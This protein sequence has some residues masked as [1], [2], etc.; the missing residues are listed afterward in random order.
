[1]AVTKRSVPR[2]IA[3]AVKEAFVERTTGEQF[4]KN[5]FE[6][7]RKITF[8]DI[9]PGAV[10]SAVQ[11]GL[12]NTSEEM[13]QAVQTTPRLFSQYGA[14]L[15]DPEEMWEALPWVTAGT[16]WEEVPEDATVRVIFEEFRGYLDE[17]YLQACLVGLAPLIQRAQTM[18][19]RVVKE[20]RWAQ[21]RRPLSEVDG[22][23]HVHEIEDAMWALQVL[24]ATCGGRTSAGRPAQGQT[25]MREE[26]A[27]AQAEQAPSLTGQ[28]RA[29]AERAPRLTGQRG[30]ASEEPEPEG[31]DTSG[32]RS[33]CAAEEGPEEGTDQEETAGPT[34]WDPG[35]GSRDGLHPQRDQPPRRKR[36]LGVGGEARRGELRVLVDSQ[37]GGNQGGDARVR[38]LPA[39]E[40]RKTRPARGTQS[41]G[42]GALDGALSRS[43]R[44][45]RRGIGLSR[46]GPQH[47]LLREIT[48]REITLR[49]MAEPRK[50]GD[51]LRSQAGVGVSSSVGG[52]TRRSG[53]GT[54]SWERSADL[55]REFESRLLRGPGTV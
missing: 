15:A 32:H 26:D 42:L 43:G 1:M 44:R 40:E 50:G 22:V 33:G 5:F 47:P 45:R 14:D 51:E 23:E 25:R 31:E 13:Q 30:K 8:G 16:K 20:K 49:G 24:E 52:G 9:A 29:Q 6:K 37:G 11:A 39:P 19:E 18:G 38:R 17:D 12:L 3:D 36:D 35:G 34:V 55:D 27:R 4:F 46:R 7:A 54:S 53:R 28:T 21:A 41:T 10:T 2:E 48:H